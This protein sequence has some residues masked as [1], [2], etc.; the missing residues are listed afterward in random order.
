MK[1][2]FE[3]WREEIIRDNHGCPY[4][5]DY[6]TKFK[7]GGVEFAVQFD[8]FSYDVNIYHDYH[9][10]MN[11]HGN[12]RLTTAGVEAIIEK[13]FAKDGALKDY[14]REVQMEYLKQVGEKLLYDYLHNKVVEADN[15]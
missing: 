2:I 15:G 6:L 4:R 12:Q 14:W 5:T 10:V 1:I 11:I 9:H 8:D 3:P 7:V 13:V